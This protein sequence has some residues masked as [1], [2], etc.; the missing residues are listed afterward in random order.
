MINLVTKKAIRKELLKKRDLLS[1][2]ERKEF[3]EVIFQKIIHLK[4]YQN[5][6]NLLFYVNYQSEV[7]TE[8]LISY[9][10]TEGK[11]VYCPKVLSDTIMEFFQITKKEDLKEGYRGIFEPSTQYPFSVAQNT[12]MI[13]PMTGF[14]HE[15]NRLGYGKGYYDRFL[16]N[17]SNVVTCGIAY[18]CQK[19]E[20]C[21]PIDVYDYKLD[22]IVTE[23][24]IY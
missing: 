18:E 16:A 8:K 24:T 13:L 5:A 2:K 7:S 1:K 20:S 11:K 4:E 12:F 22:R 3:D 15:K 19:W 17:N 10:L 14:D 23:K 21:L 6:E 9:T